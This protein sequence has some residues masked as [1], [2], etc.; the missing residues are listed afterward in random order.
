MSLDDQSAMMSTFPPA[1]GAQVTL[2]NWRSPPFNRWA[3]H[4][5]REIIPTAEIGI[6]RMRVRDIPAGDGASIPSAL[7]VAGNDTCSL[8]DV[9]RESHTDAMLILRRGAI[10]FEYYAGGTDRYSPH[11]LMS[12]SKSI[13][14]LVGGVLSD[15]GLIDPQNRLTDYIP[16]LAHTAYRS[17]RL[18][19][20]LDMRVGIG[21]EE[22]Y[23]LTEGPII[24]YRK[25]TNWNPPGPGETPTDLR[26]FFTTLTE[27]DGEHGGRFHY[28]STN[29]DLLA[30]VFERATGMRYAD[31]VAQHLWQP[32][33][34]ETP[35][36]ITVDRLGAPRAAGGVCV[37]AR[38]LARVGQLFVG[39]GVCQGDRVISNAWIDDLAASADANAWTEGD[40]A[41]LL[42]GYGLRYRNKWY[43][44]DDDGVTLFGIGIH[45]QHLFVDRARELVVVKFSSLPTAFAGA[46]VARN[47]EIYLALRRAIA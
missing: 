43:V 45:G 22:D 5:V 9:L 37:T 30:W 40:F 21:F 24:D 23:E 39:G 34:A 19:H 2:G 29:T 7:S 1:V 38:D 28:M 20:L 35:A 14:G 33:G 16:E 11:I 25:A 15:K 46:D 42:P 26:Q 18:Q 8:T 3:F 13:L 12:V 27:T 6:D 32:L 36:Y 4:H 10:E 17:A 47:I 44:L 31:L 41:P